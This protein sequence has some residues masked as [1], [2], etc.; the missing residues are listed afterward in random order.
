MIVLFCVVV[1]LGF[2]Y[3]LSKIIVFVCV[4]MVVIGECVE[5]DVQFIEL[6]QIGFGLVGVLQC[7]Q[8]LFEVEVQLQVIE[9]VD[10]F[11]VG[12]LVYCVLFMGLFKYL[13]DFVGQYDLVG[14][15]V[16]F[17]VMGG[18][19][20][21]VLIIEYQFCLLF[22]FFQVFIFL[23]GVYVSN[24]DFDGYEIVFEVLWVCIVFVVE[25]VLLLVGYVVLCLVEFL[26]G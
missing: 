4:I 15:L 26:V 25:C 3:E 8:L 13:F 5:V 1:V 11:I 20:K 7:D 18:G 23:V 16:L 6:I 19:E 17:V 21:Y 12:S 24:I 14:K 10:L 2:L 22:V 9:L